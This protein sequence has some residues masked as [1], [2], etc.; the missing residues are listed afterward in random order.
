MNIGL[1]LYD[2][3]EKLIGSFDNDSNVDEFIVYNLVSGNIYYVKV[4]GCF[5]YYGGDN[6]YYNFEFLVIFLIYLLDNIVGNI[7]V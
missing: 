6:I 5:F 1:Y 4:E 7:E 3:K 2:S